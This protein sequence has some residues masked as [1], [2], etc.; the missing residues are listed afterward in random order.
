MSAKNKKKLEYKQLKLSDDY[1]YTSDEE[2]EEQGEQEKQEEQ[3]EQE[4]QEKQEEQ[5]EESEENK[6]FKYIENKS[7]DIG[8]ILFS[9]YFNFEKP[10]DMAKNY[11]K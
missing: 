3:E 9:C 2:Q 7:K 8:Y 4:E 10:S 6:F 1:W 5:K 11:L